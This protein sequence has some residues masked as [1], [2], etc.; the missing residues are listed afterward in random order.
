MTNL[1]T[2]NLV[3]YIPQGRT[4]VGKVHVYIEGED[5]TLCGYDWTYGQQIFKGLLLTEFGDD[6][7]CT[8]CSQKYKKL[9][10]EVVGGK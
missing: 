4:H 1:P 8:K 9:V 6:E 2:L 7:M 3:C 10:D 5:N